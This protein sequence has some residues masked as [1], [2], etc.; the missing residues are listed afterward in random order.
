MGFKEIHSCGY[1]FDDILW[2]E[3]VQNILMY[4][5]NLVNTEKLS[6]ISWMNEM[7]DNK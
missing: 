3:M 6:N 4:L 1:L 5:F 2:W 7:I